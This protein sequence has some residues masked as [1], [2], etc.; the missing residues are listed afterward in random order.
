MRELPGIQRSLDVIVAVNGNKV[1][2]ELDVRHNSAVRVGDQYTAQL[3]DGALI[4]MRVV[5]FRSAEDYTNTI[6]RRVDAMREG[7]AGVPRTH[8]ARRAYQVKLAELRV[9]GE[10]LPGGQRRLGAER[11][12]DV[13]VPITRISDGLL[14]QF[15]TDPDGNLTLGVLRSGG[16][17]LRRLARIEQNF[18]GERMV[19]LGMPGKGKSQLIRSLLSQAM[20][21]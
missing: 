1:V 10:L 11:V 19:V 14:E 3:D 16:R 12:P 2:A 8:T 5:G 6:A 17:T 7:V 9:E 20:S 21:N 13:M 4:I 18:A 15:A